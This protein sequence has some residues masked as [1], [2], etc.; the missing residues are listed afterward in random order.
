VVQRGFLPHLVPE[1]KPA[2]ARHLQVHIAPAVEQ[3]QP[4]TAMPPVSRTCANGYINEMLRQRVVYEGDPME[5]AMEDRLDI[6]ELALKFSAAASRFN[7]IAMGQLFIKEG[8]LGGV[9]KLVGR[10]DVDLV[11]PEAIAELFASAFA[12]LEFVHHTSQVVDIRVDGDRATAT[13]MIIEYARPKGGGNL[14]TVMGDYD[15]TL[16]RTAAGWKFS[17]R[18]LKV[19]LFTFLAEVTPG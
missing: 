11:G 3:Q 4:T 9:A 16:V 6:I 2:S 19:R 8:A 15:D 10:P 5:K 17:R 14:M 7:A 18:A 13:T 12:G 1:I